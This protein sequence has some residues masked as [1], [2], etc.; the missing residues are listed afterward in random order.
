MLCVPLGM[1]KNRTKCIKGAI[2]RA[3]VHTL[4]GQWTIL[5]VLGTSGRLWKRSN[6]TKRRLFWKC[7]YWSLSLFYGLV[8]SQSRPYSTNYYYS[9][10]RKNSDAWL[11]R[12]Q[13]LLCEQFKQLKQLKQCTTRVVRGRFL[14]VIRSTI[15][16]LQ[17]VMWCIWM[18]NYLYRKCIVYNYSYNIPTEICTCMHKWHIAFSKKTKYSILNCVSVYACFCKEQL[19]R[20]H[21][22]RLYLFLFKG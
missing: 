15:P 2:V 4:R 20:T 13:C 10:L 21:K 6:S 8:G 12:S 16:I 11:Y 17:Q 14:C 9:M 7:V 18:V 22:N 1:S 19:K 3:P 5:K